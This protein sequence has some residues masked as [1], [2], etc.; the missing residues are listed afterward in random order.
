VNGFNVCRVHGGLGLRALK[1]K[2]EGAQPR[3]PRDPAGAL[4]RYARRAKR[5][6]RYAEMRERREIWRQ[7]AATIKGFS[8]LSEA[9]QEL[10]I[11]LLASDK[12]EDQRE[13]FKAMT[14]LGL[15]L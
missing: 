5:D 6:Q 1:E 4:R 10:I 8:Q 7:E 3:L 2:R 12:D 14:Y 11:R 15:S 13:L 9:D